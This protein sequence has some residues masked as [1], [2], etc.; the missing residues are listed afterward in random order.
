MPRLLPQ[1]LP[2]L[3]LTATLTATPFASP[4]TAPAAAAEPEAAYQLTFDAAGLVASPAGAMLMDRLR[5]HEPRMDQWID[6]LTDSLGLDVT[7]DLGVVS[8]S[9]NRD[10]L[11]DMTLMADLGETSGKLEGWMLTLPGYDSE[12]LDDQ[13]LLHGFDVQLNDNA[14]NNEANP[15]AEPPAAPR[16]VRVFAA[17]PQTRAGHF[18]LV[19]SPQRDQTVAMA[20][21]VTA[22]RNPLTEAAQDLADDHLLS[23]SVGRLPA[24]LLEETADQPGAAAWRAVQGFRLDMASGERF[25][26]DMEV[27]ASTAARG[28]QLKQLLGGMAAMVQLMASNDAEPKLGAT[29][30][31]LNEMKLDDRADGEPGLEISLDVPQ[32]ELESWVDRWALLMFGQKPVAR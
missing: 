15:F 3:L 28:R 24:K 32:P 6:G 26:V 25:R 22:A 17:L 29:A 9:S 7:T 10:D 23:L 2:A 8:L 20:N 30:W 21:N 31:F 5:K 27:A 11:T 12:D 14:P 18:C 4:V 16:T 13:T 1:T 19:A